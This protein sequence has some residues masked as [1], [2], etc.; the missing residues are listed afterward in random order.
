MKIKLIT[1][2]K[3]GDME[4]GEPIE[5]GDD[6]TLMGAIIIVRGREYNINFPLHRR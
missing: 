1:K 6:K 4:Q 3:D 2:R 5:V